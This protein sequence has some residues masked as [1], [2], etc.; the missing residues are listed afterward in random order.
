MFR[1]TEN[2]TPKI[3][4]L[5]PI[6]GP[7]GTLVKITGDF[8][9]S[10]YTRDVDSCGDD[11]GQR[12]SRIYF[13]GQ[14]C[15]L[16]D[17]TT[18]DLYQNVTQNELVCRFEGKE[19]NYFNSTILVSEEFGRSKIVP[20][21]FFVSPDEQIYNFNSYPVI[22]SISHSSGSVLGGTQMTIKGSYFYS[23]EYLPAKIDISGVPCKVL[24]FEKNNYV[25]SELVCE[26]PIMPDT[27]S[28]FY[29]N[30]GI[31]IVSDDVLTSYANLKTA[32]PGATANFSISSFANY[33]TTD[34][35]AKTV[36]IS[37][38]LQ[39]AK[40]SLYEFSVVTNGVAEVY[41]NVDPTNKVS[42]FF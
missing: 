34:S 20:Q 37:G 5:N 23:D 32:V 11:S 3:Y 1:A 15:N 25:D 4:A 30:R 9:T 2:N 21:N 14:I 24:S 38:Y 29:G 7:P 12:I 42:Q 33:T 6:S 27:Q 18:N 39:P 41:L 22:K 13:G 19:I 8:K 28:Q 16:I 35:V 10:C 36:W 17:P 40:T 26:T 31:N